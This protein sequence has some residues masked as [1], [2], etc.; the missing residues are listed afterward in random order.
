MPITNL[1]GNQERQNKVRLSDT[2][3]HIYPVGRVREDKGAQEFDKFSLDIIE[4]GPL[5]EHF[6][7]Y[8]KARHN[9]LFTP[10]TGGPVNLDEL[11][12][13]TI[14]A[15]KLTLESNTPITKERLDA[16]DVT[17]A[18]V[19]TGTSSLCRAANGV[20]S[21]FWKVPG[22]DVAEQ[23]EQNEQNEQKDETLKPGSH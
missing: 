3:V 17:F 21:N 20:N 9:M 18:E 10:T 5:T 14:K 1:V 12:E 19:S 4:W 22:N 7:S 13:Q 8:L 23:N 16:A 2:R 6:N 11:L 15:V